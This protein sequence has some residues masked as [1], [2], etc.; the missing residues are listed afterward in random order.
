MRYLVRHLGKG[1]WDIGCISSPSDE[2]VAY[3]SRRGN[4]ILATQS[5]GATTEVQAVSVLAFLESGCLP[6]CNR[7]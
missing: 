4:K 5:L 7:S 1:L 3:M 2:P 6:C